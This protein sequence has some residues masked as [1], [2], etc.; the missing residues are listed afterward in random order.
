MYEMIL[1]D[2]FGSR[3]NTALARDRPSAVDAVNYLGFCTSSGRG[4]TVSSVILK[5]RLAFTNRYT[6]V[7]EVK[8]LVGGRAQASALRSILIS[9]SE[10]SIVRKYAKT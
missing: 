1:E 6:N 9:D 10:T 3:S 8:L 5:G 2:F 4:R 7:I